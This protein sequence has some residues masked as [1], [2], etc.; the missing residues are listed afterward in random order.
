[1]STAF[2]VTSNGPLGEEPGGGWGGGDEIL[3][4]YS[5]LHSA[6]NGHWPLRSLTKKEKP[7][8]DVMGFELDQLAQ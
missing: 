4:G 3:T 6:L 7:H 8:H 5:R 1:V 2:K